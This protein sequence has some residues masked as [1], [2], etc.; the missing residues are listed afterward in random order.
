MPSSATGRAE[1]ARLVPDLGPAADEDGSGLELEL[2]PGPPVRDAARRPRP[3][4]GD[5]PVVFI[6]EDL[7]WS[8]RSTRDLLGFLV[9]NLRDVRVTLVLTYRSDELHRRHP[10]LP[11]LA[12]L[13]RSGRRRATR[14]RPVRPRRGGAAAPRD[15]GSRPRRRTSS[16]R[17]TPDRAATPSSP[18]SC[19]SRPATDRAGELPSTLRD[20]LLARVA[21][22]AEPTQE[23]LRVASAAGQRVDPALL[24]A[25]ADLD[26]AALYDALRECV[27]PPG[28]GPR[29]DRPASS[30]TPSA[31]PCSRR[32]STTTC[33]PGE[34]T[35]L[36][37]AFARTLEA[38]AAGDA[39]RAAELA[40]HWYAAHDLPRAL[41]SAVAAG[42]AAERR[43]AFPEALAQYER[44]LELWGQVPDAE[45]RVGHDRIELLARAAG[46]RPLPRRGPRRRPDPDR[47]QARRRDRPT[48][49][50]AEPAQRAPRA[51]RLDRGP[52]RGGEGRPTGRPCA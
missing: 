27:E 41:E 28:P 51:L 21:E 26:E 22:L 14:A 16:N 50:R 48:R 35:R 30:A 11:F 23:F 39:T 8:D 2:G 52:G 38:S 24:A 33:C 15:R 31:T 7:H 3:A 4:R 49:S 18:R 46:R 34:R 12:E 6:V 47:D 45:T 13:D 43:Y 42:D 37:A 17:S 9:R 36:H 1:L 32:R 44:V 10:L 40:Y 19:W 29:P 5:A 20:V 25:A